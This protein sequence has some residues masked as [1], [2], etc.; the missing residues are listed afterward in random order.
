MKIWRPI[1]V[2]WSDTSEHR[3]IQE[4]TMVRIMAQGMWALYFLC[5]FNWYQNISMK[6]K[7]LCC[8]VAHLLCQFFF[9]HCTSV[10]FLRTLN[11]ARLGVYSWTFCMEKVI[12]NEYIMLRD[13]V[14]H[15]A[16]Y[17]LKILTNE[18]AIS[19]ALNV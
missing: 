1:V 13:P 15:L 2:L 8:D 10:T 18:A 11:T 12:S 4:G 3:P 19:T 5:T 17:C 16:I 9:N 6:G 7:G 14:K